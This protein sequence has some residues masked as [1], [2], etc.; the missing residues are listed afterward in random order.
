MRPEMEKPDNALVGAADPV[1]GNS[2]LIGTA[3]NG[4]DARKAKSAVAALP[5][6]DIAARIN[7][8]HDQANGS[9]TRLT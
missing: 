8:A 2:L 9:Y 4:R 6:A 5:L 1:E 3:E 7:E